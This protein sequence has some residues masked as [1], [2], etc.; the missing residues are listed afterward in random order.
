M[1][2]STSN[3]RIQWIRDLQR[4]RKSRSDEGLF[5]VEGI[6]LAEEALATGGEP[7]LI[8]HTSDPD[9]RTGRLIDG[10]VRRGAHAMLVSDP[11]LRSCSATESPQGLVAV[12]PI[13]HPPPP[14]R[15]TLAVIVDGVTDPGNLGALLR[16]SL[17]AGA[18]A[19]FLTSGTV[20]A[21]NPKVV[22]AAMGAHFRL[23]ILAESPAAIRR[24]VD[25][26]AV[27]VADPRGGEPIYRLDGRSPVALVVGGEA[28][29][30]S[31]EWRSFEATP[32]TIPIAPQVESLNTAA[33]AAVILFEIRRQR[34]LP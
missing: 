6:R 17:A 31:P 15:L 2:T 14:D 33:A 23:P 28:R 12:V 19:V 30:P 5:V 32:V 20:D 10:F 7:R 26:L 29:G 24:R 16:T 13:P 27:W 9:E 22:R 8:L 4:K 21:Y 25:G 34:G 11:V 1:I 3:P 18:E